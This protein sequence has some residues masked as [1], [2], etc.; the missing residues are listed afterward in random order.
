MRKTLYLNDREYEKQ[1][2]LLQ[3]DNLFFLQREALATGSSVSEI[4]N[5]IITKHFEEIEQNE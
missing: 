3:L 2:V 4:L 1:T 5:T